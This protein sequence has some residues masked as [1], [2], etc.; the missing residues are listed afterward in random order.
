MVSLISLNT[1]KIADL[2]YYSDK[3]NIWVCSGIV[4]IDCFF[5][6]FLMSHTLFFAH[7]ITFC[8]Q[9]DVL[10]NVLTLEIGIS[11][12]PEFVVRAAIYWFSEFWELILWSLCSLLCVATKSAW[13]AESLF[14]GF[15]CVLGHS[16][17][18]QGGATSALAF[19]SCFHSLEVSS[20][21]EPKSL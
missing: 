12:P 5:F 2:K 7:L 3:P 16:F 17:T 13:L 6:F 10:N 21:W 9:R 1:F 4:S 15:V 18:G 14:T 19:N 8:W 20:R 11:P